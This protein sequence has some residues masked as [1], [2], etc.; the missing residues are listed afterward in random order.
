MILLVT[1]SERASECSAALHTA[2]GEEVVVANTL[3]R[4]S[5]LLRVENYLAVV[6][7]QHLLEAEPNEAEAT[8]RHMGTAIAVHVNFAIS[9]VERVVREV[10]GAL[11]RRRREEISAREAAI[12]TLQSELN[13]TVTAL[14]LATELTLETPALPPA[15]V[16]KLKSI[17]QL[18]KT[19]R[20]QLEVAAMRAVAGK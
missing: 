18:L 1:P 14:L 13:G 5:S 15:A 16:E 10:R 17:D 7:D 4:A 2:T 6:L 12:A 11:Q 3:A 20:N 8:L 19:L 9:G